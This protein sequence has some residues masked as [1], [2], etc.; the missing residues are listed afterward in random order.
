MSDIN[1]MVNEGFMGRT[2]R[3]VTG[4]GP[5]MDDRMHNVK[6]AV[7]G[8]GG[9]IKQGFSHAKDAV[10]SNPGAAG[11]GAA[12]VVGAGLLAKRFLSRK[13]R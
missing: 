4:Q 10:M 11:A 3:K 6:S 9:A 13:R 2:F 12:G 1:T 5:N 8:A 7:K